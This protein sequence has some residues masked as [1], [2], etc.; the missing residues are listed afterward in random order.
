L[1][2]LSLIQKRVIDRKI[3][4]ENVWLPFNTDIFSFLDT[5]AERK[6][7][8]AFNF[9]MKEIQQDNSPFH[10]LYLLKMIIFEFRNLLMIKEVK[11]KS[12]LEIQKKTKIHPYTLSKIYPLAKGFSLDELKKIY[13]KLFLCDER[14]KRGLMESELALQMLLLDI[15]Q[16]LE[17]G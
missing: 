1:K 10:L 12:F 14:I 13:Q 5:L 11:A 7:S 4:E 6:I 16:I 15:K 8:S 3:L 2:K 9:L 17:R